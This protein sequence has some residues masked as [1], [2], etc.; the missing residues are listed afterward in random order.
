MAAKKKQWGIEYIS[1][2]DCCTGPVLI[3]SYIVIYCQS[4]PPF[5][6]GYIT[7]AVSMFSR[8]KYRKIKM[9]QCFSQ[10]VVKAHMG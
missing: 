3:L 8:S 6:D 4:P 10:K 7:G 1:F 9:M 5:K 2:L